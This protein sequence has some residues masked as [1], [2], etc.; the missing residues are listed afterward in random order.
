MFNI[1][2]SKNQHDLCVQRVLS[3]EEDGTGALNT[4]KMKFLFGYYIKIVIQQGELT[5]SGTEFTGVDFSRLGVQDIFGQ[6]GDSPRLGNR[7]NCVTKALSNLIHYQMICYWNSYILFHFP[8]FFTCFNDSPSNMG[9]MFCYF[10][11]KALF[12]ISR[13][14]S[15]CRDFLVRQEKRPNQKQKGN[16]KMYDM[17]TWLTNSCNTHIAQYLTN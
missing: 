4:V 11:L 1:S 16:F 5:L 9:K 3:N 14:L 2:Q 17:T 10:I 8:I 13:Y 7:E 6:L 15:F 12:F